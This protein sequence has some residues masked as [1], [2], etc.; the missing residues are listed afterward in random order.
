MPGAPARRS[1]P[2]FG[3]WVL[4]WGWRLLCRCLTVSLF[5]VGSWEEDQAGLA[6]DAG[7]AERDAGLRTGGKGVCCLRRFACG[8][9]CGA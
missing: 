2:D 4:D 5:C 3:F 6:G 9:S 8:V 7:P 1:I